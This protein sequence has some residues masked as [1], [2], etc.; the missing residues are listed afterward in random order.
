MQTTHSI[1]RTVRQHVA[2]SE[3]DD[4]IRRLVL[5]ERD[6]A[7]GRV[8]LR[9]VRAPVDGVAHIAIEFGEDGA[10]P[11]GMPEK[12]VGRRDDEVGSILHRQ[13]LERHV[14]RESRPCADNPRDDSPSVAISKRIAT[15][16]SET[17][18]AAVPSAVLP[19]LLSE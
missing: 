7:K 18:L 8:Q 9:L 11:I 15:A 19:A 1:G 13:A 17:G 5:G 4:R 2:A 6:L 10:R 12:R 16:V 14:W 3:L